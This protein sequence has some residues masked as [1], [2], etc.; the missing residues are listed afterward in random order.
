ML[1]PGRAAADAR[2]TSR[3]LNCKNFGQGNH[4]VFASTVIT[5]GLALACHVTAMEA[6]MTMEPSSGLESVASWLAI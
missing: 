4:Y 3:Q 1:L 6:I 5:S 2:I